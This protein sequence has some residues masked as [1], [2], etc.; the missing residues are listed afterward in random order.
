M[1]GVVLHALR[2]QMKTDIITES[3]NGLKNQVYL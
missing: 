1:E 2:I 3:T